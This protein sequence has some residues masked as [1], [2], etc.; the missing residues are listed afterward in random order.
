MKAYT[1]AQ[2]I[3][4]TRSGVGMSAGLSEGKRWAGAAVRAMA[5]RPKKKRRGN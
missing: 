1:R 3:R 4:E 5:I 2:H